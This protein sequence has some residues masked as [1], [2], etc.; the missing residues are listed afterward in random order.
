MTASIIKKE[1]KEIPI[2]SEPSFSLRSSHYHFLRWCAPGDN[3]ISS[4]ET[5]AFSS[6]FF[7][8]FISRLMSSKCMIISCLHSVARF[9]NVI[10]IFNRQMLWFEQIII[11][12]LPRLFLKFSFQIQ[13][14]FQWSDWVCYFHIWDCCQYYRNSH[15][16]STKVT[17]KNRVKNSFLKLALFYLV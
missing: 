3:I 2:F 8:L 13:V 16:S 11:F 5:V 9:T 12:Y 17:T 14:L 1:D 6:I 7:P 15:V 4:P 10:H